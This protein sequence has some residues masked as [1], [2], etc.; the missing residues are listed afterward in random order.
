MRE[1]YEKSRLTCHNC[2]M[3]SLYIVP[4]DTIPRT[5][6][7]ALG[8]KN[9]HRQAEPLFEFETKLEAEAA[10]AGFK[11]KR[12]KRGIHKRTIGDFHFRAIALCSATYEQLKIAQTAI[13]KSIALMVRSQRLVLDD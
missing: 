12:A 4:G 7:I 1:C 2:R 13:D 3:S 5:W 11:A 10:L 6:V 9:W 8:G